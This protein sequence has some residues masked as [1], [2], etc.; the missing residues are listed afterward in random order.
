MQQTEHW[1]CEQ[2][3]LD[4]G[5]KPRESHLNSDLYRSDTLIEFL[6]APQ[7]LLSIIF[8]LPLLAIA[9]RRSE[10]HIN[11]FALQTCLCK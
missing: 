8:S 6:T 7:L 3:S 9:A 5:L 4:W 11:F 1:G 2:L 10:C